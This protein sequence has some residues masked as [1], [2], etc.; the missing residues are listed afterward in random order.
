MATV[1]ILAMLPFKLDSP[2][3]SAE[4]P[5]VAGLRLGAVTISRDSGS[6]LASDMEAQFTGSDKDPILEGHYKLL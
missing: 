2:L 5:K 6:H 3:Q 4:S 1:V